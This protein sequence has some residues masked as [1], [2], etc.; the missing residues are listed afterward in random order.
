MKY[1]ALLKITPVSCG[2]AIASLLH[3]FLLTISGTIRTRRHRASC[4]CP[5][6]VVQTCSRPDC[7]K[8]L[9]NDSTVGQKIQSQALSLRLADLLSFGS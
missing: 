7:L 1:N 6:L 5:W 4:I 3:K 8:L 9:V 2:E